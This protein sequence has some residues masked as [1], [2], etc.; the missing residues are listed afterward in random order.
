MNR[1]FSTIAYSLIIKSDKYDLE[2]IKEQLNLENP[3]IIKKG[4][5]VSR[6]IGK[7]KMNVYTYKC[8]Y[9]T[10]EG[11]KYL[12]SFLDD[13]IEQKNLLTKYSQQ[14]EVVIRLYAQS[15]QAQMYFEVSPEV[16]EKLNE[17]HLPI[18]LSILSWG[19]VFNLKEKKSK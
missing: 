7:S 18:E 15:S 10:D 4:N 1:R 13:L 9:D 12:L 2:K 8:S 3:K 14:F 17:L 5:I 19:E 11:F 6:F 16:I